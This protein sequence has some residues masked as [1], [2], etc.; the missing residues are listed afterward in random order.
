[1]GSEGAGRLGALTFTK[2]D[3]IR[4]KISYMIELYFSDTTVGSSKHLPITGLSRPDIVFVLNTIA[5]ADCL[6]SSL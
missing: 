2:D 6:H 4:S 3:S 5:L 1:M